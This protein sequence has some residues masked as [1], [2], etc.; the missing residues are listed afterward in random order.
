MA[1]AGCSR[2]GIPTSSSS[3]LLVGRPG[4]LGSIDG[5]RGRT[6]A[7]GSADSAQATIM[8]IYYLGREGLVPRVDVELLRFDSDVGKH[9]DTGRS[10]RE[11]LEALLD[12]TGR[13]RRG[14]GGQLGHVRARR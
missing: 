4:D 7:V 11:A 8:P 1:T 3:R 2:C 10:E 6:L 9:G 14:G 5:L 13:R 12:R